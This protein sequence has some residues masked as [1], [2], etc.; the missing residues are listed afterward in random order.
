MSAAIG[1][2]APAAAPAGPAKVIPHGRLVENST[3]ACPAELFYVVKLDGE[4]LVNK[5]KNENL[6]V[7]Q[8]LARA[9]ATDMPRKVA[10]KFIPAPLKAHVVVNAVRLLRVP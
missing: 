8:K 10:D 9:K 7:S 6:S 4:V 5:N 1:A 3:A 2:V